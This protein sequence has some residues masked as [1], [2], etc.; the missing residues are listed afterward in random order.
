VYDNVLRERLDNPA[1]YDRM[2]AFVM[3][4]N[5]ACTGE[6]WAIDVINTCI[7]RASVDGDYSTGMC[8]AYRTKCGRIRIFLEPV[9]DGYIAKQGGDHSYGSG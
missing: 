1:H 5:R 7:S 8:A 9:G 3:L 6:A 2:I 4:H